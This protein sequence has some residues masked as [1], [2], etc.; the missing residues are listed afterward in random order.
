MDPYFKIWFR[1]FDSEYTFVNC[2]L[3]MHTKTLVMYDFYLSFKINIHYNF[4][5]NI[6]NYINIGCP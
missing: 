2:N 1:F 5:F 6:S 3:T 4:I